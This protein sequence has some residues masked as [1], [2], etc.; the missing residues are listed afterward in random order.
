ML[1]RAFDIFFSIFGLIFL[2]PLLI[3]VSLLI[4][5][6][7]GGKV[8]Y[9]QKRVGKNAKTFFIYKFRTMINNADKLGSHIT[10]HSD[11]RITKLG[12]ILRKFKIDEFPQLFNVL[13][14]EMSFVG[15]RP[16]VI[17]YVKLYNKEQ[18]KVLE[19][20]PGITDYSSIIFINENELLEKAED[21]E[22]YYIENIMPKKL[23]LNLR[24]QKQ[25][26]FLLD[27]K[28]IL[29]TICKIIK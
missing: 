13:K 15:P 1:K 11:S 10:I 24:Y 25:Q 14:G 19:M 26:S 2:S 5:L 3:F 21:H 22:K 27:I 9:K 6:E 28:L 18:R 16:E 4:K 17:K 7:D 12:K 29:A 23:S 8:L 20:L